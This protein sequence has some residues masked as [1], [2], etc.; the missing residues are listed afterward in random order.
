MSSILTNIYLGPTFSEYSGSPFELV[1]YLYELVSSYRLTICH[2][3]LNI[4]TVPFTGL[5]KM[6]CTRNSE[7][8]YI[9]STLVLFRYGAGMTEPNYLL[10]SL[11]SD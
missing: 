6:Y 3:I 7:Q 4:I 5:V 1:S 10:F 9:Y 8:V 2:N 11:D